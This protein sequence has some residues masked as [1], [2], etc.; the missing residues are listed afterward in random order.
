[1]DCVLR[2]DSTQEPC[3]QLLAALRSRQPVAEVENLTWKDA[4]GQVRVNPL[5]FIPASLDYV[6][7]PAY[8]SALGPIFK[9]GSM[10]SM[11]PYREWPHY[12]TTMLLNSRGRSL[13]CAVCG[14]SASACRAGGRA[15]GPGL[16]LPGEAG[17]GRPHHRGLGAG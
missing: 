11:I 14:G 6:D 3:R 13:Q 8:G 9:Y 15:L 10:A 16:P 2:G 7:V 17:R 12:P 5:T 4:R 1:M